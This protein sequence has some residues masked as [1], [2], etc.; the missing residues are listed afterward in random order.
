MGAGPE[1]GEGQGPSERRSLGGWGGQCVR[2]SLR[3]G[4]G[5]A[6]R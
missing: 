1:A 4:D 6:N 5:D 3:Y 2:F